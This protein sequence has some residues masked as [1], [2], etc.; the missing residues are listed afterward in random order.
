MKHMRTH[1]C[2]QLRAAHLNERVT[3]CGWVDTVRDHGGV[4]FIDLR[5]RYGLTQIIFD[6]NDSHEAWERAQ[7]VRG[8]FVI[9][10]QGV[11]ELRPGEMA[12]PRLA[13]GEIE[14]RCD[15]IQI[16][17]KSLTPP[18]PLEDDEAEKVA[19]D[20]RL[21]HRY[22]DLR[23]PRM[24]ANLALRHKLGHAVRSHLDQAGFTE[25][26][27]P[28][29][30]KST[31]EGARDYLVPSRVVPG[32]FY[33]LPQAPQQYKQLLMIAGVD[34]YFQIARCFRDEDLRA[35]RQPEF[36]QIDMELS[37]VT[38]EDIYELVDGLLAD[39]MQV[40]GK[41]A[42]TLPIPRLTYDD[43]VNRYGS[44]KPDVRFDMELVDLSEVFAATEFKVFQ[45]VLGQGGVVKAV[46][47]KGLGGVPIRVMDEWTA[48]AKELGLG[49]LAYIRAQTDGEWKS[50]ILKFFSEAEKEQLRR[51][52]AIEPGDL[53]FFAAD[54]R[55]TVNRALGHL[56]LLAGRMA[57][58]IADNHFAF[59]WV[60]DFPLFEQS[61]EGRWVSVHHPFTALHPE[62]LERLETEPGAIRAQAYDIVLNGVELGGGSIRIHDPEVQARIFKALQLPEAEIEDRFG[63]LI[64]A[65]A[66]GAPPHGGIALGFDRLVMMLAGED[67]IRDVIAFPKTQKAMDLMMN[68]PST[69]DAR[70]LR[71]V[72]IR[73]D[74]LDV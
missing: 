71:D 12:N 69:V 55:A 51:R 21:V 22:L 28:I 52:L 45:Q 36:T 67:S 37:F 54:Q 62:D 8:E 59:T 11:V 25:V 66:Y 61:G 32:A 33:A 20:L 41:G 44:D 42:V 70:Q 26:E 34:R 31:P 68:A 40:A 57:G 5:D 29:L 60:T 47:A 2:G 46:N 30:T 24:Q 63:H 19:E 23:R 58:V 35:D 3:L 43:A 1:T 48:V 39:V 9:Q 65:L 4:L 56:R 6:P 17:N 50:P 73:L 49:G 13:T 10:A 64:K 74:T 7:T 16:L 38:P 18:F 27:T 72:H 15:Q 14:V 53:V